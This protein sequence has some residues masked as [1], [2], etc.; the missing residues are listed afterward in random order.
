[1]PV[2]SRPRR[3][4]SVDV[5]REAGV[6]RTTVS[7]VLNAT[8][9]Q[10]IPDG[11]RQRVLDAA[12][13]LGYAPSAAARALQSGRSDVVLYLLPDWP[14]GPAV[15]HTLVRLSTALAAHGYTLLAYPRAAGRP[16]ADVWRSIEPAAVVS[17]EDLDPADVAAMRAAGVLVAVALL[18][19]PGTAEGSLEVSQQRIG[20]MQAEHLAAAGHRRLG[21]ADPDDPRVR[22]FA[23]PRLDGVRAAC[24]DL[25]LDEPVVRT[26]PPDTA[27]AADAVRAWREAG[28]TAVCAYNDDVALAVLAGAR[29]AGVDVPGGLAVVGVDDVPAA[30]LAAPPLTTVTT[31]QEGIA[32][33]IAALVVAGLDG[34]PPPPRLTSDVVRLVRRA[35]A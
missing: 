26:V 4:T 7:Y 20:R 2:E 11:T 16:V 27:T 31:D 14:V 9:H 10:K 18:R 22:G 25:G 32:E 17:W 30:A 3:V 23:E 19:G 15:T 13:R 6:S 24:A 29:A 1:M 33:H 21:Y 5:A 34:T 28:V 35:S 8:P 12:A